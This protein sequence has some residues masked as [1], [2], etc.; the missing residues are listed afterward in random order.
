MVFASLTTLCYHYG[1]QL[2]MKKLWQSLSR[3][4]LGED[5]FWTILVTKGPMQ[6]SPSVAQPHVSRWSQ[7]QKCIHVT[8]SHID[9]FLNEPA[10]W[11][12]RIP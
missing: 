7:Q 4:L 1:A 10:I 2:E 11:F 12:S 6:H 9:A 8:V 5:R 3:W